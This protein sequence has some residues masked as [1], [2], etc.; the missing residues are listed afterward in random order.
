[1]EA[2]SG[3]SCPGLCGEEKKKYSDNKA[4]PETAGLC[5]VHGAT[6]EKSCS[7]FKAVLCLQAAIPNSPLVVQ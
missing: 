2:L 3:K 6:G 5:Y 1:M 7:A 4:N